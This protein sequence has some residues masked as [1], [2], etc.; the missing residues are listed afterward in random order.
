[1]HEGAAHSLFPEWCH[2]ILARV[3]KML[4]QCQEPCQT[5]GKSGLPTLCKDQKALRLSLTEATSVSQGTLQRDRPPWDFTGLAGL[6]TKRQLDKKLTLSRELQIF[7]IVIRKATLVIAAM[8][9]SLQ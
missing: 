4:P 5:I 3:E 9:S 6:Q 8:M 2:P 1:L 7:D